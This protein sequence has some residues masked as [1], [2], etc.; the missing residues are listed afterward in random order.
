MHRKQ[1]KRFSTWKSL[2]SFSFK[3]IFHLQS[4]FFFFLMIF[5]RVESFSRSQV[6]LKKR[7]R[8]DFSSS[9]NIFPSPKIQN[10]TNK[11]RFIIKYTK[12]KALSL[13]F[14]AFFYALWNLALMLLSNYLNSSTKH[15]TCSD[16]C[17]I[18]NTTQKKDLLKALKWTC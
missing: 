11:I 8:W 3:L 13:W 6:E 10:E 12:G 2:K 1:D 17:K 16:E 7:F 14:K 4:W 18:D 5:V 9:R 15:S